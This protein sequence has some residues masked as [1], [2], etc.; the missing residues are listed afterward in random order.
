MNRP[1][2]PTQVLRDAGAADLEEGGFE[3][4][5]EPGSLMQGL[6]QRSPIIETR[7]QR[8]RLGSSGHSQAFGDRIQGAARCAPENIGKRNCELFQALF[9]PSMNHNAT[10]TSWAVFH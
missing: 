7:L 10:E 5:V 9:R 2:K 4:G 8:H 6:R 1:S 3:G